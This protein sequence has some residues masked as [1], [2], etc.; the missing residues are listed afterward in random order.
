MQRLVSP[1]RRCSNPVNNPL[2]ERWSPPQ[3]SLHERLDKDE[4]F[5]QIINKKLGFSSRLATS[6]PVCSA[7]RANQ[8]LMNNSK[9]GCRDVKN[10]NGVP[11]AN[12]G[13]VFD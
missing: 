4:R 1:D 10:I 2:S 7:S 11:E 5:V 13:W 12:L 3:T 6:I 8:Y 9:S